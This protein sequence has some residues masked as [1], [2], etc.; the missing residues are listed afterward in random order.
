MTRPE[1]MRQDESVR[2][3][4]SEVVRLH[5]LAA[6]LGDSSDPAVRYLAERTRGLADLIAGTA[7]ALRDGVRG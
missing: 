4:E 3:L 6:D 2:T 5:A 1:T 7:A